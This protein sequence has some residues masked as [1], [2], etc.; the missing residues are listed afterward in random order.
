MP[1][2]I[3]GD[4][5]FVENFKASIGNTTG[6]GSTS[7]P[8]NLESEKTSTHNRSAQR[9]STMNKKT[10]VVS[11]MMVEYK[12]VGEDQMASVGTF[13]EVFGAI[14]G[15]ASAGSRKAALQKGSRWW[16][17]IFL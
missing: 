13:P 14:A 2:A 9:L 16:K 3:F 17:Q 5:D 8:E 7:E 12:N 11:W 10:K 15:A 1:P 4:V 6:S